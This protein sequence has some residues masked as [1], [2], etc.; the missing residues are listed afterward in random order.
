MIQ[1]S[2]QPP[3]MLN[4]GRNIQ[5]LFGELVS[6]STADN[7]QVAAQH[8]AF[9]KWVNLRLDQQVL[10]LLR[11]LADE[12]EPRALLEQWASERWYERLMPAQA[13]AVERQL[14]LEQFQIVA[15]I[16]Y[17]DLQPEAVNP[18]LCFPPSGQRALRCM[19][20]MAG[21]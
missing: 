13:D 7:I 9:L 18:D 2:G 10:H 5:S 1:T 20:F 14:F 16:A 4:Y 15:A 21:S 8:E 12:E 6:A 11:F 3:K 19:K 17:S